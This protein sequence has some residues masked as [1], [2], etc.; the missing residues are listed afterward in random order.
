MARIHD[1]LAENGLQFAV[2]LHQM[3]EDLTDLASS[4]DRSRKNWKQ[5]GMSAE[6]KV[7]DAEQLMEKVSAT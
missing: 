5:V 4:M 2:S 1:R 3:H 7:H 6:K